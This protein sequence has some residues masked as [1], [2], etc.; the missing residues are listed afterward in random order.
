MSWGQSTNRMLASSHSPNTPV[1]FQGNSL[2]Q[3]QLG[4]EPAS[5]PR[6]SSNPQWSCTSSHPHHPGHSHELLWT[7]VLHH[8]PLVIFRLCNKM[9]LVSWCASRWEKE[10]RKKEKKARLTSQKSA[11]A[12][13]AAGNQY[14]WP[15]TE[16]WSVF[17][18]EQVWKWGL[19]LVCY[20]LM[21]GFVFFTFSF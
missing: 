13:K 14:L 1:N 17:V 9:E 7:T 19:L 18:L 10:V 20:H 21:Q 4:L 3:I 16:T 6:L 5:W 2:F 15:V 11:E 8:K 12:F